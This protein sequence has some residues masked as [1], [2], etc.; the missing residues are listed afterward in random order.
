MDNIG[1]D[2]VINVEHHIEIRSHERSD[3]IS[4]NSFCDTMWGIR[5]ILPY[6][7]LPWPDN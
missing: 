1:T 5:G 7:T 6:P 4:D 2:A 3:A